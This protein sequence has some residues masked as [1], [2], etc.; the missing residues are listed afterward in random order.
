MVSARTTIAALALAMG[1]GNATA[2]VVIGATAISSPQGTNGGFPL[3]NIINQSSLSAAYVSGVTDFAS[4]TATTT[5]GQITGSG[6]TNTS[7]TGPQQFTFDLGALFNIDGIAIWNTNSVGAV[8]EFDVYADND[9]NFSN[10]VGTQILGASLLDFSESANVF[11]FA[12]AQTRYIHVQGL[13]S[14]A[15][16]DFYGLNEVVFSSTPS[17]VPEPATL[18]LTGLALAVMAGLRLRRG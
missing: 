4:Y 5:S 14:L 6:F 9:D 1:V 10:G 17:A 12:G 3:T 18:A 8:S 16:P 7:S 11:L 2:G 13:A 15:P